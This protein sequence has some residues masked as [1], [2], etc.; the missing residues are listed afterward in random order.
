[1]DFDLNLNVNLNS[2]S[3]Q[4]APEKNVKVGDTRPA[5]SRN[6]CFMPSTFLVLNVQLV[7]SALVMVNSSS[8]TD[9]WPP[10]NSCYYIHTETK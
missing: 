1:M 3:Q 4:V 7:V 10:T 5:R 2:H 8:H 9:R 6:F